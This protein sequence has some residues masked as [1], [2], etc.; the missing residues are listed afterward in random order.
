MTIRLGAGPVSWFENDFSAFRNESVRESHLYA[1]ARAGFDGLCLNPGSAR[2]V[3]CVQASL[4]RHRLQFIAPTHVIDLSHRSAHLVFNEI[5][6]HIRGARALGATEVSVCEQSRAVLSEPHW[7]RF[8]E[9]LTALSKLFADAGV[10]LV[11]RPAKGTIISSARTIDTLFAHV[12]GSVGLMLDS[13]VLG[14]DTITIARNYSPRIAL[15]AP[16]TATDAIMAELPHFSGWTMM[17][18]RLDQ[19]SEHI[20]SID[21]MAKAA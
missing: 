5:E 10:R 4:A 14:A 9:R 1:V 3:A 16:D 19:A 12:N 2:E 20:D 15:I 7:E 8:G 11:Y 13:S 6:R 17:N 21:E 18:A